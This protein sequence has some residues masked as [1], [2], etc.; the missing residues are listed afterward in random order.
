MFTTK[1][2]LK[3]DMSKLRCSVDAPSICI[4]CLL[5]SSR[6]AAKHAWEALT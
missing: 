6:L 2:I 3:S 4:R 5:Y 1:K